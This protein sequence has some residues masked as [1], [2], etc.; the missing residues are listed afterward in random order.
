M[1]NQNEQAQNQEVQQEQ[2]AQAQNNIWKEVSDLDSIEEVDAIEEDEKPL[3]DIQHWADDQEQQ[4][5]GV[6][7]GTVKHSLANA[8]KEALEAIQ[9]TPPEDMQDIGEEFITMV[10]MGA[11]MNPDYLENLESSSTVAAGE[12]GLASN[13]GNVFSNIPKGDHRFLT[14]GFADA[15]LRGRID[16]AEAI[17]QYKQGNYE[18]VKEALRRFLIQAGTTARS[19]TLNGLSQEK[20]TVQY[21]NFSLAEKFLI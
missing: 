15:L 18:P 13:Q 20:N 2:K 7:G 8:Q 19:M 5:I 1:P 21:G 3:G 14:K 4:I 10:T 11:S 16:A 6:Y 17:E 9:I 12:T